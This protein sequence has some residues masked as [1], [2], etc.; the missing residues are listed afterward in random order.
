[1]S[2]PAVLDSVGQRRIHLEES[3]RWLLFLPLFI[4]GLVD[5]PRL[6][7]FGSIT[8]SGVMSFAQ[9]GLGCV[10]VLLAYRYPR[11]VLMA[12]LPFACFLG[13]MFTRS[14]FTSY[15]QNE[16]QN[17]VAYTLFGVQFL[18]AATLAS[19]Y[20]AESF[21]MIRRGFVAFDTLALGLVVISLGLQGLP[22]EGGGGAWLV[23]P[24]SVGILGI[25]P[26]AWHAA[27]WYHGRP[28]SGLR[29]IA[30]LAAVI[31]SLSRMA[32]GVAVVIVGL[33]F[34]LQVMAQPARFVRRIPVL[35]GGAAIVAVIILSQAS[36][37]Y[38]RFFEGYTTVDIAG[39][40]VSTSG[41]TR[42]WPVVIESAMQRP[43]VG[44]GIGSSQ[45]VV[46]A[47][48]DSVSI[49]H[50]HND[51]LRVWHDG[52]LIGLTFLM[53]AFFGFLIRLSRQWRWASAIA[54]PHP[55]VELAAVLA[56]L[57]LMI[58]G[59][60]DNGFVYTSVVGS[61]GLLVG[62][63]TGIRAGHNRVGRTF[64]VPTPAQRVA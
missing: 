1:M 55:E 52:G 61:T 37:F 4:A 39:V 48:D 26:V 25:V 62:L 41:R 59:I 16:V 9:V 28:G 51:Y 11:S 14:V 53:V 23:G 44:H 47:W 43:F 5:F 35:I 3:L 30:W 54:A 46:T 50:P 42:I 40:P 36:A 10:G 27:G 18:L 8:L 45:A 58:T 60:T 49:G 33:T 29:A 63:A 17:G 6:L 22:V 7:Q 19:Q 24:R 15:G 31:V 32:T 12:F 57:G 38:E 34:M 21:K 13:W 20:P 56:L 64:P 2:Y